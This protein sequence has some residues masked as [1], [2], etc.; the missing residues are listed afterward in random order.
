MP[1]ALSRGGKGAALQAAVTRLK[2]AANTVTAAQLLQSHRILKGLNM[3]LRKKIWQRAGAFVVSVSMAATL[4]AC[5]TG[6]KTPANPDETANTSGVAQ[7]LVFAI[8]GAN[9]ENGHMDPHSSQIDSTFYVLRNVYDSLIALDADGSFKPWLATEWE[10][11]DDG[12]TY[13]FTL[14]QDV[15]F[16]DGEKFDAAAAVKNFEHV[17]DPATASTQSLT[18]L[19][20]ELFDSAEATGDFEL[21]LHLTEPFAPLLANLS[22]ASLGFYS[23]KVLAEKTQDELLAGGPEVNVGTGPFV[24]TKLVAKQE[25]VFAANKDYAWAPELKTADGVLSGQAKLD[26]LTVRIVPEEAGRVGALQASDAQVAVNLTP[27]GT[28]QLAGANINNAPS[29]GMPHAAY[30]NWEHGVFGDPLVRQAFQQGF[31]LDTAVAAAFGGEYD[32]AWSILS[33]STPNSYDPALEE[34]WPFDV[35]VANG[36]LDEAGWTERGTDGIRTKDGER[37]SAEWLSWLPFSDENQALVNFMIDDLKTIGFEL[38]H[39][40]VEGPEYQARYFTEQDGF[41][42]DFDI[43]DWSYISLDADILRQHLFSQGYQNATQVKDSTLDGLLVDAAQ[44]TDP[45][46]REPL[47]QEIQNWNMENVAIVPLYLEQFTTASLPTV[48]GLLF[49]SYGWPLFQGVTLTK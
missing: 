46:Q 35:E 40:A 5:S 31:D 20:S 10:I 18:M 13:V 32:R 4:A 11:S 25:I 37:L 26:T 9:L 36:F 17:V 41:I 29:P 2:K 19:G 15:T 42:L 3:A 14:R 24:M 28:A 34:A 23:P 30:I 43:T 44:L 1:F 49:D 48:D 7:D 21:T 33:P 39:Q 45:A 12:K 38:K 22:T 47:Y 27:T 16:H 6:A 8:A